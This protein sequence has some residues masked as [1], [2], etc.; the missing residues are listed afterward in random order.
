MEEPP[1]PQHKNLLNSAEWQELSEAFQRAEKAMTEEQED[2]WKNL[3]SDDQI[4]A[5]CAVVR[6]IVKGDLVDQGSYRHVL[7]SVFGWGPESYVPMQ[8]AGY[9]ELHNSIYSDGHERKLL[10][11]FCKVNNLD[12]DL[13]VKWFKNTH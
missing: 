6:R 5:A 7:Y 4:K 8:L 9:L 12:P 13:V 11:G 3:S 2:F 10:E 1:I